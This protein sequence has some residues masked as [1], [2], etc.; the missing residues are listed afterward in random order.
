MGPI[1][2]IHELYATEQIRITKMKTDKHADYQ[3]VRR[4]KGRWYKLQFIGRKGYTKG[5]K[6]ELYKERKNGKRKKIS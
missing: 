1:P 2:M 3:L 6:K 5:Y 4:R